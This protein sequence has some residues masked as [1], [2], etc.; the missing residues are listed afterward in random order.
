MPTSLRFTLAS[1]GR[2]LRVSK[3]KPTG[4]LNRQPLAPQLDPRKG[5]SREYAQGDNTLQLT[6]FI[7]AIGVM[8][9]RLNA[10][11]RSHAPNAEL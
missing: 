6:F 2:C 3:I 9:R 8:R 11:E 5:L 1:K 7:D 10:L 4:R